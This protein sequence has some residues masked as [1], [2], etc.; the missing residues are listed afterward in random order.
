MG[1]PARQRRAGQGV[2][3]GPRNYDA[4]PA[5]TWEDFYS[6]DTEFPTLPTN[7]PIARADGN[8]RITCCSEEGSICTCR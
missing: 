6:R 8:R 1:F 5:G 2:S 3:T 7:S 4:D